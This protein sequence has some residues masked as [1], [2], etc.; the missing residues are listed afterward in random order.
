MQEL[1]NMGYKP[2]HLAFILKLMEV[3]YG[4]D[5]FVMHYNWI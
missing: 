5:N 3:I 4:R 1:P 2:T